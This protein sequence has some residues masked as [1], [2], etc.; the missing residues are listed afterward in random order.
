MPQKY[1]FWKELPEQLK[2]TN[3][4]DLIATLAANG[5]AAIILGSIIGLLFGWQIENVGLFWGW[6]GGILFFV[7]IGSLEQIWYF[8]R[9]HYRRAF[10]KQQS[11]KGGQE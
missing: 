11:E 8:F 3:W 9:F 5:I 10:N 6:L 4:S 1:N 2:F 7:F